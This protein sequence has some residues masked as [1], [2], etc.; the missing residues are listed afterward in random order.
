MDL[1]IPYVLV[2]NRS[3]AFNEVEAFLKGDGLSIIPVKPHFKF[4]KEQNLILAEGSGFKITAKFENEFVDIK[5]DLSF[6]YKAFGNKVKT[7]LET[8]LKKKL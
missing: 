1:K 8:Q 4:L 6:L 7:I 5:I 3:D 2:K